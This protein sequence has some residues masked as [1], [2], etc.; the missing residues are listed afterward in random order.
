[1]TGTA[2]QREYI[3]SIEIKMRL[4]RPTGC[5]EAA[6]LAYSHTDPCCLSSS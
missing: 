2:G 6:A 4:V 3:G 5:G 1:V